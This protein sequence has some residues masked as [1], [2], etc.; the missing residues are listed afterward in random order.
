MRGRAATLMCSGSLAALFA[1]LLLGAAG[2]ASAAIPASERAAL[3]ALYN[4]TNGAHWTY[5][6]NWLGASGTECSWYGVGC[7][8]AEAHVT[9]L[10]LS[11]N[12]LRGPIPPEIGT[13]TALTTLDLGHNQLTGP[14]PPEIGNLASLSVLDLEW[15]GLTGPI[16]P[17]VGNLTALTSLRLSNNRGVSGP[18]APEIINLVALKSLALADTQVSGPIPPEIGS[19]KA[20]ETLNLWNTQLSG[21]I[22]P[23]IG[24]LPALVTLYLCSLQVSGSIPPEIGNLKALQ[25]LDLCGTELSGPIPPEIGGLSA[26][27]NL[28]LRLTHVSGSIP[29][30]IGGLSANGAVQPGVRVVALSED[31]GP[32]FLGVK[33][34]EQRSYSE[35]TALEV[36]REVQSLV[37]EAQERVGGRMFSLRRAFPSGSAFTFSRSRAAMASNLLMCWASRECRRAFSS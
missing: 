2:E 24:G 9:S 33:G 29:P 31:R 15:N 16:P 17:E 27:V 34:F 32:S 28:S 13:L 25:T 5:R 4:S 26:L 30:E 35:Q 22:P 12:Y 8:G 11:N 23:E 36:D 19:L 1:W 3:V 14:I 21:P 7:D 37:I 6:R 20:L 18:I 10:T